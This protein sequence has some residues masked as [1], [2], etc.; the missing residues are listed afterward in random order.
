MMR[1]LSYFGIPFAAALAL[2]AVA[3]P[4]AAQEAATQDADLSALADHIE[5]LERDIRTLNI[6]ISRGVPR[7]ETTQPTDGETDA[8]PLDSSPA[9][10]RLGLRVVDLE[11]EI[12]TLTGKIEQSSFEFN[13]LNQNIKRVVS[14]I[15]FRLSQ[16]DQPFAGAVSDFERKISDIESRLRAIESGRMS[17]MGEPIAPGGNAAAA[18]PSTSPQTTPGPASIQLTGQGTSVIS[19]FGRPSGVLGV[20]SE[21]DLAKIASPSGQPGPRPLSGSGA[22]QAVT[23]PTTAASVLPVETPQDQYAHAFELLR[24]ADYGGAEAAL[25]TFLEAHPDDALAN[26]ARYWLGET[27][28]VR[29]NY[30]Q[31]AQTFLDGY[32]KAPQGPKAPDILLKLGMSMSALD[33]K[34][35]AC[36]TFEELGKKFPDASAAIKRKLLAERE[37]NGC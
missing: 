3:L 2:A 17:L 26:N 36:A 20:V 1:R 12:R 24:R 29:G 19:G 25:G 33:K 27:Y 31:A 14:D 23:T 34:A 37:K 11:G 4:A 5:R 22:P 7:S 16:L 28:Y 8:A 6:Q 13:Q 9:I 35:Q 32:K 30:V 15:E 18:S 21:A 10:V